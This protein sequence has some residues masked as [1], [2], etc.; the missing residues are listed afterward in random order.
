MN[1]IKCVATAM[2]L[3]VGAIAVLPLF[4]WKGASFSFKKNLW[5]WEMMDNY[6]FEEVFGNRR[7]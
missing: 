4:I 7:W 5:P 6:E 2:F 1:P 3:L